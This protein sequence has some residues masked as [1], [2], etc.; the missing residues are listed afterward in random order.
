MHEQQL[1]TLLVCKRV[2]RFVNVLPLSEKSL[3]TEVFVAGID[4]IRLAI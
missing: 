2:R 4:K 1:I 3:S